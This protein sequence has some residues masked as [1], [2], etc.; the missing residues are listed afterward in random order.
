MGIASPSRTLVGVTAFIPLLVI[1]LAVSLTLEKVK[2][3]VGFPR[4]QAAVDR[5]AV[6]DTPRL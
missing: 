6:P 4:L 5:I 1:S 2:S 3:L